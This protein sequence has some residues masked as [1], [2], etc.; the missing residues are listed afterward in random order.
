[1][2]PA[3]HDLSRRG[4]EGPRA[5]NTFSSLAAGRA[6]SAAKRPT[7]IQSGAP[8]GIARISFFIDSRPLA[9]NLVHTFP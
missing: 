6:E 1:M 9:P 8:R 4:A 2:S 3:V 5:L 7:M